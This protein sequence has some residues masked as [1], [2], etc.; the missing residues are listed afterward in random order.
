M[1]SIV[2]LLSRLASFRTEGRALEASATAAR[3][4]CVETY[5]ALACEL[6]EGLREV[7]K[8]SDACLAYLQAV[9][10]LSEQL[11][12]HPPTSPH[13]ADLAGAL[14]RDMPRPSV[15]IRTI[16]GTHSGLPLRCL[17]RLPRVRDPD[18]SPATA[19]GL[20][21]GTPAPG[22]TP[23]AHISDI[24]S[25]VKVAIPAELSDLLQA[26]NETTRLMRP[27]LD[28]VEAVT[29]RIPAPDP[30]LPLPAPLKG[31]TK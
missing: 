31:G 21:W 18:A 26:V 28:A 24:A 1:R 9:D 6:A 5:M 27:L 16:C 23:Q 4:W 8:V 12:A 2:E 14:L 10:A 25:R 17:V 3:R 29:A 7:C 11:A 13:A 19:E 22:E 15:T 30:V 20:W